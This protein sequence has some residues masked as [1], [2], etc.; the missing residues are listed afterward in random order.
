MKDTITYEDYHLR[1]LQML[2][3]NP[4]LSQREVSD[5]I[6][7]SL[8]KVNYILKAFLEK[9]VLKMQNF[10]NNQNK[11]GYA[12]LLTPH[13]IEEKARITL[14]FYERKK[15]EYEELKREVERLG[16]K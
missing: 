13:G 8:G 6:G 7:I 12:Y 9:G 16:L 11:L 15:K 14:H 10:K 1:L 5:S 3:E 4:H 2:E